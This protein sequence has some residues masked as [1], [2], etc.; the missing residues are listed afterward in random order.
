MIHAFLGFPGMSR[1][2]Q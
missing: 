2:R 1:T